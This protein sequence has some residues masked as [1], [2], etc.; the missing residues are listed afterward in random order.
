M[1]GGRR[2]SASSVSA[3]Q[4][5]PGVD[6]ASVEQEGGAGDVPDKTSGSLPH[7]V[8]ASG[9]FP[10]PSPFAMQLRVRLTLDAM[11]VT[12]TTPGERDTNLYAVEPDTP[13]AAV[14]P[15]DSVWSPATCCCTDTALWLPTPRGPSAPG[16]KPRVSPMRSVAETIH[17]VDGHSVK[18]GLAG[19]L[20]V[21]LEIE[22][23]L[24]LTEQ[25]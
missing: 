1:R 10:L 5:H 25:R 13:F 22:A 16:S 24:E 21:L 18:S 15:G 7:A 9:D 20:N 6:R 23:A 17:S 8:S 3:P 12:S 4:T 2:G 11:G 14:A 19:V